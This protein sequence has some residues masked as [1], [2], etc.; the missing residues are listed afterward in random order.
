MKAL[1]EAC[2]FV[3]SDPII[4]SD[5]AGLFEVDAD[6]LTSAFDQL[7]A[8]YAGRDGGMK[9][10]RVG[11]GYQMVTRPDLADSL[12]RFL[13]WPGGK[14]RLTRATLETMA[15]IAYRQPITL[16]EI[17]SIRGVSADRAVRILLDRRLIHESGRKPTPGRPIIY[18]TSPEFLHYFGMNSLAELPPL[19]D[20]DGLDGER[21]HVLHEVEAV[22][23]LIEQ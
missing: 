4:P 19:E 14:A 18:E 22:V 6:E 12:A 1:I 10:V 11:G 21:E 23:G 3:A 13:V 9:I 20:G 15:I 2:L 16:A 7:L 8:E 5:V 17:E